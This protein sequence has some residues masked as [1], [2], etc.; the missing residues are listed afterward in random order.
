MS[1]DDL[2]T[3]R[4]RTA[5]I[6]GGGRGIGRTLVSGLAAAGA[7]VAVVDIDLAGEDIRSEFAEVHRGTR[8]LLLEADVTDL[9]D[10]DRVVSETS[11]QLGGPHIL[12]NNAGTNIRKPA[13]EVTADDWA[14]VLDLNLRSYFFYARRAG[15][16]MR[17][18]G[19][20]K[21]INLA[22]VMALSVFRNPH[23]QTYAPY[24][25]SKG[26]VLSLTRALAVEWAAD[27]IQVNAISPTFIETPL[28]K[29]LQ[30]DPDVYSAIKA[31]TPIGRFG[32]PDELIGPCVFLASRAS[33]LVTGANLVVDGGWTAA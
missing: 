29:R 20:G 9:E 1:V 8:C 25:A 26:G 16:E 3:L 6:T 21:V 17:R 12:V 18:E 19:G 5:L 30:D 33:D 4:G 31:R 14:H 2:F 15:E 7:D 27:N 10:V 23:A 11:R 13:A 28:T 24:A 32:R 22:S